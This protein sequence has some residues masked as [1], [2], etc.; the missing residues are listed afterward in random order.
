M[1]TLILIQVR[2]DPDGWH[3]SE[4]PYNVRETE[5]TYAAIGTDRVWRKTDLNQPKSFF[6]PAS[7][8]TTWET[9]ACLADGREAAI[10]LTKAKITAA[11]EHAHARMEALVAAMK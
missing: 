3:V 5:K 10:Y 9:V 6:G 1:A 11:V 7:R 4:T 2:L 8:P